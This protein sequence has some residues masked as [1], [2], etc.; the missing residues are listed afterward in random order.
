M[1]MTCIEIKQRRTSFCTEET[2]KQAQELFVSRVERTTQKQKKEREAKGKGRDRAGRA[3]APHRTALPTERRR[4]LRAW[5]ALP[6]LGG[7]AAGR[8]W[9]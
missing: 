5:P 7:R 1:E 4:R 2:E 8:H 6:L 3:R 9:A